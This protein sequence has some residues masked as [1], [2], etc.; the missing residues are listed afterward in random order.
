MLFMVMWGVTGCDCI[1]LPFLAVCIHVSVF[2]DMKVCGE[3]GCVQL[4]LCYSDCCPLSSSLVCSLFCSNVLLSFTLFFIPLLLE[5]VCMCVCACVHGCLCGCLCLC[6]WQWGEDG[7]SVSS[8]RPCRAGWL[9]KPPRPSGSSS[10]SGEPDTHRQEVNEWTWTNQSSIY[11]SVCL[12][13]TVRLSAH[14]EG[15]WWNNVSAKYTN[16]HSL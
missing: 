8:H 11:L 9:C 14:Q 4:C 3:H 6:V 12:C 5:C 16:L 10:I 13:Q 2:T 1:C 15:H 7:G